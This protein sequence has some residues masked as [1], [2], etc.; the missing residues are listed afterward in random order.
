MTDVLE[1]VKAWVSWNGETAWTDALLD[2]GALGGQI[3]WLS[4][5]PQSRATPLCFTLYDDEGQELPGD[6]RLK[7][8]K[9][10]AMY[11][12]GKSQGR[13]IE[14]ERRERYEHTKA[15]TQR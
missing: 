6:S 13:V 3:K 12:R 9:A 14:K 11:L 4:G 15:K 5:Y 10:A 1:V 2:F 7:D 8:I